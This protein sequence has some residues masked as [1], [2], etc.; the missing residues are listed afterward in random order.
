MSGEFLAC[1]MFKMKRGEI[2][3]LL[4]GICFGFLGFFARGAAS[5]GVQVEALLAL[6]YLVGALLIVSFLLLMRPK[7]FFKLSL[8]QIG[9]S[10][11]LGIFGYALFST[12]YFYSLQRIPSSE[13]VL[14]LYF[15][16]CF[17]TLGGWIFFREKPNLKA[18]PSFVLMPLGLMLLLNLDPR[19]LLST[20]AWVQ[21]DFLGVGFGLAAAF[22]YSIY[23]LLSAKL[24]PRSQDPLATIAY[25]QLGA[26]LILGHRAFN[27][28]SVITHTLERAPIQ[29]AG[30]ALVCTVAAMSLFLAGLQKTAAWKASLYSVTE[31]MTG[32]IVGFSLLGE[33]I[34]LTQI[35]GVIAVLAGIIW[36]AISGRNQ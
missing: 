35:I 15:Y 34:A 5:R 3:L 18:G 33:P 22:F 21:T 23:I 13:A 30:L 16:P 4:S 1:L 36:L 11:G 6:R 10:L 32:V 7:E 28:W 20:E 8:R 26:G 17:V 29:I 24:V 2:Q 14:L 19:F 27:D 31:P 12:L 25:V 9:I